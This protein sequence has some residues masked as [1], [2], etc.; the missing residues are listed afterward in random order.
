[1]IVF[2]PWVKLVGAQLKVARVALADVLDPKFLDP[3]SEKDFTLR[4]IG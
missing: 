3:N 4:P 2:S 1:M